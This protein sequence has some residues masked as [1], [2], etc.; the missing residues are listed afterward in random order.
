MKVQLFDS[1]G[2]HVRT[3][4]LGERDFD[5][6]LDDMADGF[7]ETGGFAKLCNDREKIFCQ[8]TV[9]SRSDLRKQI[10]VFAM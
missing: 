5:R 9:Q 8:D 4:C 3:F 10:R 7:F 1:H 2:D 6:W